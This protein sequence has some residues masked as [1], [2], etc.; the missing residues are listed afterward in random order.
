MKYCFLKFHF[1]SE[2]FRLSEESARASKVSSK[3]TIFSC[4]FQESLF[5]LALFS[6]RPKGLAQK[7]ELWGFRAR[8]SQL[9]SGPVA[10]TGVCD[11]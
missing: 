11:R 1:L 5:A 6:A 2:A 4:T 3:I 8:G 9:H 10:Q 7:V